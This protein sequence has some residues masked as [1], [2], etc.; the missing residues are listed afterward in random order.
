LPPAGDDAAPEGSIGAFVVPRG[1][2]PADP[3]GLIQELQTA[4]AASLPGYL[5]PSTIVLRE[6]LP[7]LANGAVDRRAL[8]TTKERKERSGRE[9]APAGEIEQR[10]A[11][12]W[13]S[14]LGLKSVSSD[15][16]F[17]ELGGHSLLAARMLTQ[18]ERE[19]GRRIKL[20]TLF[21]APTLSAFAK[22]LAQTDLRE[23][24]FRQ[25]VKIQPHGSRRPLIVINNTGIYY[26]LAKKLGPD[27][28]VY[29]LQ[30]FDP[31]VRESAL[32]STLEEI[33]SGYVGL[34]RRVQPQGPY[35]LMGWCVAGALAFEISRQ[36]A[37]DQQRVEHL[38]LIDSWVPGYFTRLPKLKGL[39]AS[40]SLRA[41]LILADWRRVMASEKS[42]RAFLA[43]RTLVKR[44]RRLFKRGAADP[45]AVRAIQAT[46]E[47]YDQWLLAY[48]QRLTSAYV[49]KPYDGN[50]Q[51]LRS[52]LEPTGWFFRKDAGWGEFAPAGVNVQFVDGNHFTM[53]QD[54]GSS[55]M[56]TYV[57]AELAATIASSQKP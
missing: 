3:S 52:R 43:Q 4:L 5:L 42:I 15:E 20:A 51:L 18:V 36:L 34:I 22:V 19:F 53:F 56:A 37:A 41:Q 1:P 47:T 32:P 8:Q 48:L 40:Y 25:V 27:Q 16:N 33:A 28:P 49:P 17:F 2:A 54:P 7:Q 9:T 50:V 23:F 24:D 10:L 38:F 13:A 29:S 11:P 31:S 21:L 46:P 39:I 55:Q 14:M 57:A 35:D 44:I 6:S 30:L 12:I 26:G 45:G